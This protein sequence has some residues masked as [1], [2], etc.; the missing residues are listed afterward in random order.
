M[1]A[2]QETDAFLLLLD[3]PL[4]NLDNSGGKGAGLARL[5][6]AGFPV[7]QGFILTTPAY[8]E[9]VASNHFQARLLKLVENLNASS[10]AALEMA[11]ASI[12]EWFL[13]G[14]I[15]AHLS[16]LI[17]QAYQQIGAGPVAVRSS[18]T[19]EDLPDLSF[20]GQQDTY[21]NV[22]GAP[23]LER[24]V[25]A[26]WS[27]LWT[28][29]AIG[30]RARNQVPSEAIKL[31][32]V[33]QKMVDS[34]TSG[35]LFTANPLS[36]ARDEVVVDASFGLGEAIVSG[37]VDTDHYV[38][39]PL[40]HNIKSKRLGMKAVAAHAAPT[41]GVSLDPIKRGAAQA[42]TDAQIMQL[43]EMGKEIER[44]FGEPQDIEW[45][46]ES[47]SLYLLQS[48]PVT[49]L[50]PLPEG[51]PNAPL[52]VLASFG[53][54]QGMLA[55]MTPLGRD[56]MGRVFGIGGKMFGFSRDEDHQTALVTAGERLFV[57][58][59]PIMRNRLGRK[60]ILNFMAMIEPGILSALVPLF[61]EKQ[62]APGR[63][64][65]S[66]KTAWRLARTLL[67]TLGRVTAALWRPEEALAQNQAIIS[68]QISL[69]RGLAQ[70]DPSLKAQLAAY[71]CIIHP[72]PGLIVH[73]LVACVAAGVISLNFIKG[74]AVNL[75]G[76][77]DLGLEVARGL[78][79]NVT[80]E[81]D[82]ALWAT[83]QR[84]RADTASYACLTA[85]RLEELVE[86]YR[87]GDLPTVAQEALRDFLR[88]YGMRG[89]GEIDIGL[90]RW[91]DDPGGVI[92]SLCSYLNIPD[93]EQAP[94]RVFARGAR[95]AGAAVD[96]LA[97]R[98]RSTRAGWWRAWLV[99]K[100]ASRVRAL[101]GFRESPKFFAINM[102]GIFRAGL[103]RSG[104]QLAD[105]KLLDWP[106]D[107][108]YFYLDELA[109]LSELQAGDGS[110]TAGEQTNRLAAR[111]GPR[112][113]A[114]Q[115]ELRRRQIPRVLLSDGR[116]FFGDAGLGE[117]S[118]NR[119]SG[120][121]VSPGVVE[122]R[123]RVVFDP[124][125]AQLAPGEILVCPGTDPAWTPLFLSA[126]GLV[127]EVGGLMTHGSVVAREYGIPAIAGVQDATMR[128]KNGQKVRVDGTTGQVT[129]LIDGEA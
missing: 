103:L 20:A 34:E 85:G 69:Y 29:R 110:W 98:L 6:R 54:F 37:K 83:A 104:R 100:A 50:Y 70:A 116:V 80:T 23:A 21:L 115:R 96:E 74:T 108:F 32:V 126:G 88:V 82:L 33:V 12:R 36:G 43:A 57:R 92:Q 26:C 11:A 89:V 102:L 75:T 49:S 91:E 112:K 24:A 106:Q 35:V 46:W 68:S 119:I 17:S 2:A 72:I 81:M 59:T 1:S 60:V 8:T 94:D 18:A 9:F 25:V 71:Q 105:A 73:K 53:A 125:G 31:A 84:I 16:L 66:P 4:A 42:L 10:T 62:L 86:S 122:G 93:G 118:G 55:P 117:A 56:V 97:E 111:I 51:M 63:K 76:K 67:P 129:I 44:R 114:Y 65:V 77:A 40:Q 58:A 127:M 39:D 101:A 41:G 19:A 113:E 5:S 90:P 123:V 121:P 38:V 13:V 120:S 61:D 47:G 87:R 27:S 48:R 45:A 15:P 99:R 52:Q 109:E 124:R 78:P 107:I 22:V 3:S 64:T 28:A 30:Y 14:N 95:S 7:P 128:L 79:H